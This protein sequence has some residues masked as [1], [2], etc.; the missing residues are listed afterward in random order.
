MKQFIAFF[1]ASLR[2]ANSLRLT[3]GF[4]RATWKVIKVATFLLVGHR[5]SPTTSK[6]RLAICKKCPL[7][8]TAAKTCGTPGLNDNNGN[9][10]GCLCYMPFK[11][12]YQDATCWL[13][14]K[15]PGEGWTK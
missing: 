3:F 10:M 1:R 15:L 6:Y 14:E 13:S 8:N 4:W 2:S 9:Q 5:A 11:V 12:L 7:Y